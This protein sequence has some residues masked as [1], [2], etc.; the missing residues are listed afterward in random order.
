MGDDHE[1][2]RPPGT[3]VQRLVHVVDELLAEG[4]VAV[5]VLA[6][7]CGAPAWLK[8][9]VRGQ[10]P[11]RSG[12]REVAEH[13]EVSGG[14]RGDVGEAG[15][16]ERC[17]VVSVDGPA[18]LMGVEQAEDGRRGERARLVVHVTL[19]GRGAGEG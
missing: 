7:P 9:C 1:R 19:A 13:A 5:R 12:V 10:G 18:E 6:V 15:P 2:L 14:C 16:G 8:E 3:A 17:R 11:G 4:D